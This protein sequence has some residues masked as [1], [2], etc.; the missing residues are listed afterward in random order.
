MAKPRHPSIAAA[1]LAI[2]QHNKERW[3]DPSY[4]AKMLT[5]VRTAAVRSAAARCKLSDDAVQSLLS[6]Y[7][8]PS[9][10]RG[11]RYRYKGKEIA[12][13]F[14]ISVRYVYQLA[15][16]A[17]IVRHAKNRSAKMVGRVPTEIA[18]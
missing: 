15:K 10:K 6:L 3:S 13:R 7:M 12:A 16:D 5:V 1:R 17:N 4:R 2:S 18:A 11:S 14:C 8:E 9:V